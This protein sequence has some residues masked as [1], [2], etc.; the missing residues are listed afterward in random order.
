MEYPRRRSK[1]GSPKKAA[2][3]AAASPDRDDQATE[4]KSPEEG[5]LAKKQEAR[6]RGNTKGSSEASP[7]GLAESQ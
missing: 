2:F 6:C 4:E 5:D 3:G 7:Q 1:E